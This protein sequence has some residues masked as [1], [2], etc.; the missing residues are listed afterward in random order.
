[1]EGDYF[2]LLKTDG[3]TNYNTLSQ[4]FSISGGNYIEGWAAF[5]AHDWG[6]WDDMAEV[7]ILSGTSV[8]ATPWQASVSSLGDYAD[9]PW[10]Y[11]SWNAPA[12]GNYTVSCRVINSQD[13]SGDSY[14][15]FDAHQVIPEP[16]TMLL[17]G[18]GTLGFGVFRKR[19]I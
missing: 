17:F 1:V 12:S 8:I 14:A 18:L 19:R 7:V 3:P 9:G 11:W 16:A 4:N 10:T 5:D 13:G 2:A 15:L 6:V